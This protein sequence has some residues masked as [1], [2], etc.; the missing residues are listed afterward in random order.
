MTQTGPV[1][2]EGNFLYI[3]MANWQTGVHLDLWLPRVGVDQGKFI[4]HVCKL[5]SRVHC[6]RNPVCISFVTSL[7]ACLLLCA[8][9]RCGSLIVHGELSKIIRNGRLLVQVSQLAGKSFIDGGD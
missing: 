1:L 3:P 6:G 4:H 9:R 5:E 2:R 7:L 8:M